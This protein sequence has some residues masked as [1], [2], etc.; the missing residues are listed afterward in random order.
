MEAIELSLK[1]S[2]LVHKQHLSS[3]DSVP[4][5][6]LS[7]GSGSNPTSAAIA[8][9]NA[10]QSLNTSIDRSDDELLSNQH[11]QSHSLSDSRILFNE[12][13][14]EKHFGMFC[15]CQSGLPNDD[16]VI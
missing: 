3:R 1:Y 12:T 7:N 15:V 16:V 8:N 11:N 4:T 9:S 5:T 2:S 13:E 6:P 14:I 10:L